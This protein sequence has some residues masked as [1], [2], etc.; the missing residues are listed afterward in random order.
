MH[1]HRAWLA[2]LCYQLH[3]LA[4]HLTT[5][6]NT[7]YTTLLLENA[8]LRVAAKNMLQF[9][10]PGIVHDGSLSWLTGKHLC[11]YDKSKYQM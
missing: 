8:R 4:S 6:Y 7:A 2:Y 1:K 3:P 11:F 10:G 9:Q 5:L